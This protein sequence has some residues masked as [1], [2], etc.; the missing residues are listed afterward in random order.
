MEFFLELTNQQSK[1]L[2]NFKQL[3]LA[4]VAGGHGSEHVTIGPVCS[5]AGEAAFLALYDH[6]VF[7]ADLLGHG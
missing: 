4:V 2:A 5:T 3:P 7:L 1:L 6:S